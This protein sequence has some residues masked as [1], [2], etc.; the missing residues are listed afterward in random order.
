L[1]G[2]EDAK[3]NKSYRKIHPEVVSKRHEKISLELFTKSENQMLAL[4]KRL[5]MKNA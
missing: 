2:K 5:D 1:F 4:P 3:S